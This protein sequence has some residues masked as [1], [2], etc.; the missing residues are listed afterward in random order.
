ME[1]GNRTKLY[2]VTL[3]VSLALVTLGVSSAWATPVLPKFKNNETQVDI[4]Q[5]QIATM[6][7]LNPVGFAVGSLVTGYI[8]DRFGRRTTILGSAL[9]IAIG[10]LIVVFAT[11]AWLLFIT[12]LTWSCGSG[13]VSTVSNYYLSEIADKDVRG[14]LSVITSFMFKFGTLLTMSVGPFLSYN[15]LNNIMLVLPFLFFIV[16]FWIPE[17]PYYCLKAGNLEGA[18][19]SLRTLRGYKDEKVLEEELVALEAH[20]KNEMKHSSSVKELFVGVQYRRAIVIAAGLK[21]T[22]IMT[23]AVVIRQYL[24]WIMAETKLNLQLSLVLIIY[25][26]VSFVVGLM[27]SVLVDRVGRRPLL[28]FS[29]IGTGISLAAVGV[30]FFLKDVLHINSDALT[31]FGFIPLL[32]IILANVI[33]TVG[34]NSLIFIIP[35]EIFPLNVKAVAMTSLSLFGAALG[36]IVG[37]GYQRVKD[38]CGL[39]T[40]FWIFAGFA[41]GGSVF[42]YFLVTETKGKNL[43]DIQAELQGKLYDAVELN[44]KDEVIELGDE[45]GVATEMKELK[46]DADNRV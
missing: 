11:K 41:F 39:T 26:A 16:C 19:N 27:S 3:S 31:T 34:F 25:G 23:G 30:Y 33:S 13:M 15:T 18:R 29:Y 12:S 42:S 36:F 17:T 24:A 8:A 5:Y 1:N 10:S 20:V 40:V 45:K 44:D 9:P 43:R 32:G 14:T 7:A 35:A 46:K 4:D 37:L 6:F 38:Y 21:L 22:Q 2:L 28:I